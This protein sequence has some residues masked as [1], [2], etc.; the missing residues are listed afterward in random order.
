M[1]NQKMIDSL[2]FCAAQCVHCYNGCQME[3]GNTGLDGCMKINKDC[4][5][6]CRLT[7]QVLE[8]NSE[9]A[10]SFLKLC[11]E[12]CEKCADECEKHKDK[13]QCVKC[14]EACRKCAAFCQQPETVH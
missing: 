7:A 1:E 6:I 9:N 11:G 5:D 4:E 2:Y 12:I 14:A 13:E 8:R 3:K 10:S